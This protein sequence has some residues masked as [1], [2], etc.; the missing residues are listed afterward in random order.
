MPNKVL[1]RWKRGVGMLLAASML[2]SGCTA[3][4]VMP[5]AADAVSSENSV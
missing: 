1:Y 4:G 3:A 2:L 5:A